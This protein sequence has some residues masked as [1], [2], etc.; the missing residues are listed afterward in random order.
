MKYSIEE[1]EV[2]FA[3]VSKN[4]NPLYAFVGAVI[5]ALPGL[6]LFFLFG[7]MGGA[8]FIMLAL[9]PIMI[10]LFAKFIGRTYEVKPRISVGIVAAA[11]HVLGCYLIGFGPIIYLLTPVAFAVAFTFAKVKLEGI[12][13]SAVTAAEFGKLNTSQSKL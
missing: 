10:G 11:L 12:H 1:L 4:S 13:A 9:P 6:A 8:L 5:G 2:A 3:E 7:E